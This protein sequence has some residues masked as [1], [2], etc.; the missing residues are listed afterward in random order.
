MVWTLLSCG[1]GNPVVGWCGWIELSGGGVHWMR[2]K[3]GPLVG[4][5]GCEVGV[6]EGGIL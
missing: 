3:L 1:K 5:E 4:S 6:V 2:A